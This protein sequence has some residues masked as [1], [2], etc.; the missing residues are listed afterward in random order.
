MS[1]LRARFVVLSSLLVPAIACGSFKNSNALPDGVTC[2]S[3]VDGGADGTALASVLST[4]KPGSCVVLSSQT[5]TGN[6]K[7]PA[8]V[9]VVSARDGRATIVG[10]SAASPAIELAGG[11]GSALDAVDVLRAPG[12]G[13]A[14][15]GGAT[16]IRDVNVEGAKGAALAILCAGAECMDDAHVVILEGVHLKK[17]AIGMWV[18]GARVTMNGGECTDHASD[19]LAA[20]AGIVAQSGARLE[21]TGVDVERNRG[22]GILIDGQG[23]TTG[24]LRDVIVSN[25]SERGIWA[26]KLA[27]TM[28]APALR[29]E[30]NTVIEANRI[31]G[32]G[33]AQSHGIIFVGGKISGTTS[34]PIVTDLGQTDQVG[35]G[36]GVFSGSG[37]VRIENVSLTANS[38]T[39]GL[40]D[41]GTG[42]II[43]VGGKVEAGASS[44]KLVIQSTAGVD[45]P[46]SSVSMS[47]T[48]SV[49]APNLPLAKVL[50]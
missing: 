28:N 2:A 27:G 6:F 41:N 13:V 26:Q 33:M 3:R 38:R 8:G 23:G 42:V 22:V 43:F 11:A 29:I 36:L 19:G 1:S 14:V 34:A 32:L 50:N 39:A 24:V 48:L 30:G 37:D 40:I 49:S 4:A 46:P 21:L 20:S 44:L 35:D 31:V 9:A 18:S 15:R 45:A 12:V 7:V 25:N 5:Y 17:S 47:P 16:K 10:A